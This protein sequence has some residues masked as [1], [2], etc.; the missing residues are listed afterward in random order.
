MSISLPELLIAMVLLPLAWVLLDWFFETLGNR[1]LAR[2][3][4]SEIRTC[5]LCGKSYLEDRQVRLSTCP[6]CLGRNERR[7]HRKLG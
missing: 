3:L 4:R 7:G 5:H 6:D 1:R 2:K